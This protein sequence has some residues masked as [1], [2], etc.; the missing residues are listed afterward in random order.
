MW[1]VHFAVE[2]V[3]AYEVREG[4]ND[5]LTTGLVSVPRCHRALLIHPGTPSEMTSR[6]GGDC[7][8]RL[9]A[10]LFGLAKRDASQ[11]RWRLWEQSVAV[12]TERGSLQEVTSRGGRSSRA[13]RRDYQSELAEAGGVTKQ[14][15]SLSQG[16]CQGKD[17]RNHE[18]GRARYL[19]RSAL[20]RVLG[21]DVARPSSRAGRRFFFQHTAA[22]PPFICRKEMPTASWAA[23]A[24]LC[25]GPR[26][27]RMSE[28][29]W[30]MLIEWLG[31]YV[32][33][34]Q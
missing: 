4:L 31:K 8:R 23:S 12:S 18:G 21:A 22:S 16:R 5:P 30:E 15:R 27:A 34:C 11:A 19:G 32:L 10:A 6:F 13:S 26:T 14:C 24:V 3:T 17:C 25:P 33:L 20:D 2:V 9:I 7:W 28:S 1:F 29:A